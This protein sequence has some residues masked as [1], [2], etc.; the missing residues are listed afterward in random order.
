M[1]VYSFQE[2]KIH[3]TRYYLR[4]FYRQAGPNFAYSF[5]KFELKIPVYSFISAYSFIRELRVSK[6]LESNFGRH[7]GVQLSDNLKDSE[8][9]TRLK[10]KCKS[11]G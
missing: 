9:L 7:I 5:I 4:A 8:E 1:L 10:I 11:A 6:Y 3:P 2:K